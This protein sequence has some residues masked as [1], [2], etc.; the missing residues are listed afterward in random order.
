[1]TLPHTAV[2][3]DVSGQRLDA[4]HHPAG[5]ARGFA[6]DPVGIAAL[7]AWARELEAFVVLEATAPWD[8]PLIRAL[9]SAGLAFHRANPKRARD[10]ARSA[11][12]LAKTDAVDAR[13]LALYGTSLPLAPTAPIAPERLELQGLNARRDQ[14]VEMRKAERI[15]RKGVTDLVLIDSLKA[16]TT[17]L[18][19]QIRS[20]DRRIGDVVAQAPD[21]A[22]DAAV[23]RSAVGVGPVCASVL[24]A[25]LPELGHIG[26]RA[27]A[28]LAGLAPIARDSG[29]M[30]GKRHVQGGRKRVRDALYMAALTAVRT[31]RWKQHYEHLKALGKAPKAAIVAVARK[32]LVALNAAIR[33]QQPITNAALP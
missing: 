31:G 8:Q 9:E 21:L 26:R 17:M 23:L 28:A 7:V 5:R 33:D 10:F 3:I 22:R 6:N 29:L 27:V 25:C 18:D 19:D 30:R 12:L 15:R 13:M 11:G 32:L 4:H 24:L 14:L 2:G 1:M 20:L 16:V